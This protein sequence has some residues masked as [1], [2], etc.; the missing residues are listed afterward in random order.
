MANKVFIATSLD[1]YIAD[2][3]GGLDWLPAP[4][5]IENSGFEEFMET[6]DALVMGRNTFETVLSFGGDWFYTKPVF[7]VSSRLDTIPEHLQSKVS[8]LNDS[9]KEIVSILKEKGY[10]NLYIDGG[11]IIQ[12]FLRE[13]L[14]EEI[15][16]TTIPV[17]LG[18][19]ARLFGDLNQKQNF[20]C[21]ETKFLNDSIIQS[22]FIKIK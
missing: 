11:K 6:I 13:E 12:N 19:G 10:E 21:V 15:I 14:I 8:L 18:G 22:K 3:D 5:S 7:V 1:G 4:D 16:I 17:L 2:R 9:P 20:R